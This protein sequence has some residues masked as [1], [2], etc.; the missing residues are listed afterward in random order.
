M[1]RQRQR[2]KRTHKKGV[3]LDRL[4]ASAT[5]PSKPNRLEEL[6]SKFNLLQK[7]KEKGMSVRRSRRRRRKQSR[8]KLDNFLWNSSVHF[9]TQNPL[10]HKQMKAGSERFLSAFPRKRTSKQ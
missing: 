1:E 8:Q 6:L 2:D 7:R 10:L 5:F 9:V 4:F 3:R